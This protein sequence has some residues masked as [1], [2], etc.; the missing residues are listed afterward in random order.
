[1]IDMSK[2]RDDE[3]VTLREAAA[4]LNV[5][6]STVVRYREDGKIPYFKYSRRKVLYRV[7]DLREFKDKSYIIHTAYLE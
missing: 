6:G 1:M 5:S 7:R 3:L 4:I 2:Y